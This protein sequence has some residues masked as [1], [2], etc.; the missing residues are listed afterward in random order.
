MVIVQHATQASAS[1]GWSHG[2]NMLRLWKDQPIPQP[3]VIALGVIVG[4]EVAN[5]CAQRLLVKQ[6]HALQTRF[7]NDSH[8]SL[9]MCIQIRRS[10][11]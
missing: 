9:G 11:R 4:D 2:P 8:E 7:L 5:C 10:W 6:D 3:L 1:P